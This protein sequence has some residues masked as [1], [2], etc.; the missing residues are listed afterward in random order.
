MA[1]TYVTAHISPDGKLEVEH[2]NGVAWHD[3]PLPSRW[4]RCW[5]QTRAW[6]D[7][8]TKVERCACGATRFDGRGWVGK[9]ETRKAKR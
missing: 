8:F 1:E 5:P 4:H 9:N 6:M 7:Y 2:L 3:A